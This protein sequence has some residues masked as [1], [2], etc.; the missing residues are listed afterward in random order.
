MKV[1]ISWSGRHS[2]AVAELLQEW[3]EQILQPVDFWMSSEDIAF[4]SRWFQEI[5]SELD[6]AN[7]GIVCLTPSNLKSLW[8]TFESGA[9]AK[10]VDRARLVP[11]CIDLE[12]R[13]ITGPLSNFQAIQMKRD[14]LR[15]LIRDINNEAERQVPERTISSLFNATWDEFYDSIADAKSEAS[16][17][18]LM[19]PPRMEDMVGELLERVRSL[20]ARLGSPTRARPDYA[21]FRSFLD[22]SIKSERPTT[23][24][25]WIEVADLAWK[26]ADTYGRRIVIEPKDSTLPPLPDEET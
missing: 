13:D 20:E 2:E 5:S 9:L 26:A 7:F 8:I 3:L 24:D 4:G 10:R 17:A 11:F 25:D 6:D 22:A 19:A 1:F 14:S 18:S 21:A 16:E 12:P 15:K 23:A